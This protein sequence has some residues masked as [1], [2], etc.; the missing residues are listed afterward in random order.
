MPAST[1][2]RRPYTNKSVK[3][4]PVRKKQRL[5]PGI[6]I[7]LG[8]L[9][10]LALFALFRSIQTG[11]VSFESGLSYLSTQEKKDLNAIQ[12][13]LVKTQY[14]ELGE[15]I[16]TGKK[17]IFAAFNDSKV[18]GDSR[19]MGFESYGFLPASTVDSGPGNT[20]ANIPDFLED[21]K[22]AQP[23]TIYFGYG[24]NDMGMQIG[25]SPEDPDVSGYTDMY[26]DMVRQVLEVSP[27]SKIVINSIMHSTDQAILRASDWG[28]ADEYNALIQEMCKRNNWIYVNNDDLTDKG[29]RLE[30]YAADGVHFNSYFY[31]E[32][33][34]NMIKA[35][36]PQLFE[37]TKPQKGDSDQNSEDKPEDDSV[38]AT[39][40]TM[41]SDGSIGTVVVDPGVPDEGQTPS[42]DDESLYDAA[43]YDASGYDAAGSED[44]SLYDDGYTQ[45][46]G[47]Y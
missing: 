10:V 38:P 27:N 5:R 42:A 44:P 23:A 39:Y 7:L 29:K 4:K 18:L 47:G 6:K 19:I 31:E 41:N 21:I 20:I 1:S 40:Q 9:L 35:A 28:R 12:E 25:V 36:I 11:R 15:D 37:L 3:R 14:S 32:W 24:V 45:A 26:E 16:R 33:A 46:E 22:Q 17:T 30:I 8:A 2:A 34:Q 13:S 43:G